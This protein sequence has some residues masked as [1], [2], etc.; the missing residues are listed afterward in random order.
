M[1]LAIQTSPEF[2]RAGRGWRAL[3]S[4]LVAAVLCGI[5]AMP[6]FALVGSVKP[7]PA[8][9]SVSFGPAATFTVT[10]SI[11]RG[12]AP[13]SPVIVT[14]APGV[15][16]PTGASA[17]I[18]GTTPG[19]TRSF[20]GNPG[21]VII[22]ETF[23][24]PE[25]VMRWALEHNN[26]QFVYQ[27]SFADDPPGLTFVAGTVFLNTTGGMGGPI[28]V[29]NVNLT[30][31]DGTSFRSIQQGAPLTAIAHVKSTG[32][33]QLNAVWEVSE[34]N[35][36]GSAFYRPIR[37]ISQ[38]LSGQHYIELESPLLPTTLE[39]RENV[40]FRV[41]APVNAIASPVISYF[42]TPAAKAVAVEVLGPEAGARAT[43][44]T[45]FQWKAVRGAVAYRLQVITS[46]GKVAGSM[47]V[48]DDQASLSPFVL[49]QL[50]ASGDYQWRVIAL[51][52]DGGLL[53]ESRPRAVNVR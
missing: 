6:A 1:T 51:G 44:T 48:K 40:R 12:G 31:N 23:V 11:L 42:V 47:L 14:G 25:T 30:F 27:R 35:A 29:T 19:M 46:S 38:S 20:P 18:L 39:G 8:S 24:I 22:T 2:T 15:F 4:C 28:G 33:G 49:A 7:S 13:N 36:D 16:K 10:W 52:R 41:T 34:A 26:G 45:K 53:G 9:G 17:T 43:R 5:A 32:S 50:K 37:T 21:A 3:F